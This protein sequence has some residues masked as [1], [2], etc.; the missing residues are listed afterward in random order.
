MTYNL[1]KVTMNA[2]VAVTLGVSSAVMADLQQSTNGQGDLHVLPITLATGGY[3]TSIDLINTSR[4]RST[5]TKVTLRSRTL[6][7][8]C[9][10]F[11]VYLSPGDRFTGTFM[12]RSSLPQAVLDN[13]ALMEQVNQLANHNNNGTDLTSDT[14]FYSTDDSVRNLV[15]GWASATSPAVYAVQD[16]DSVDDG[17]AVGYGHAV[18]A[19]SLDLNLST[20][21]VSKQTIYDNYHAS[22]VNNTF[23]LPSQYP[24]NTTVAAYSI[25]NL[26]NGVIMTSTM[27]AFQDYDNNIYLTVGVDTPIGEGT[28]H[29]YPGGVTPAFVPSGVTAGMY[30]LERAMAKQ[31]VVFPHHYAPDVSASD[32]AT[33]L[34]QTTNSGTEGTYAVMTFP[35]KQTVYS[36]NRSSYR[37]IFAINVP[38]VAHIRDMQ[39]TILTCNIG[40]EVSPPPRCLDPVLPAEMNQMDVKAHAMFVANQTSYPMSTK[41]ELVNSFSDGWM[42]VDFVDANVGYTGAPVVAAVMEFRPHP[43]TGFLQGDIRPAKYTKGNGSAMANGCDPYPNMTIESDLFVFPDNYNPP[44]YVLL[45]NASPATTCVGEPSAY[46][47]STSTQQ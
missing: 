1:K 32:D 33:T 6:S 5:V 41:A 46:N 30:Y 26:I 37:D 8:E 18:Q 21:K 25:S 22:R 16:G 20:G 17:C 24:I 3:Q 9:V 31:N 38:I 34:T 2:A 13:T 7:Y 15:G 23:L 40:S 35:T 39:E 45:D 11:L 14:V 12:P 19:A 47:A 4:Y 44:G 36:I 10:D 27:D 43:G 28:A 29:S 42:N